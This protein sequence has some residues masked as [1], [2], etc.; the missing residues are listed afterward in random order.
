LGRELYLI[1]N[2][3]LKKNR[4]V[5]CSPDGAD[6]QGLAVQCIIAQHVSK[7]AGKIMFFIIRIR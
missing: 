3:G 1:R 4:L 6:K 5:Q 7:G 2:N